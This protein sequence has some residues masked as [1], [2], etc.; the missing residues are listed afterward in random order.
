MIKRMWLRFRWWMDNLALIKPQCPYCG[1]QFK[2]G[3]TEEGLTHMEE[4]GANRDLTWYWRLRMEENSAS[5]QLR[6][7]ASFHPR[8]MKLM[9]KRKAFLVVANDE[10]YY[11]EVYELIRNEETRVGRWDLDDEAKYQA[12][13]K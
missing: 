3:S 6:Q 5:T 4:C 12:E 9:N 11:R 2:V 10:P 13:I 7:L 1:T 8:A